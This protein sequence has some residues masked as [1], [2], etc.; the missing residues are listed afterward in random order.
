MFD[1]SNR[2]VYG[3]YWATQGTHLNSPNI[4]ANVTVYG[5]NLPPIIVQ[6]LDYYGQQTLA[7]PDTAPLLRL[8]V[9]PD[10]NCDGQE[11]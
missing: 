9:P 2:A 3:Q 4:T 6:L 5:E 1:D 11:G 10:S 7:H 8:A